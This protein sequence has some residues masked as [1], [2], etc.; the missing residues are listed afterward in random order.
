M[1]LILYFLKDIMRSNALQNISIRFSTHE[2]MS[3]LII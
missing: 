1:N 3:E 2:Y